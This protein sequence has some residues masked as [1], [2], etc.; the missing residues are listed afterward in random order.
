METM[1]FIESNRFLRRRHH[2]STSHAG[3]GQLGF[4]GG[5]RR[6]AAGGH[7]FV[8]DRVHAGEVLHVGEEDL[9]RQ[10]AGLV[11]A[12]LGQQAVDMAQHFAGLA[13]D[14]VR[15]VFGDLAGQIDD[16]VVDRDFRQ[17]LA[18]VQAFEFP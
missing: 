2:I 7:P 6:R 3:L 1:R 15:G 10:D 16:A 8:P 14:V 12:G 9:A 18:D 11:A 5:A 13:V 4:H 17:A